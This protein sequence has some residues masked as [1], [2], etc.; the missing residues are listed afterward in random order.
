MFCIVHAADDREPRGFT[1]WQKPGILKGSKNMACKSVIVKGIIPV[2][3]IMFLASV[4]HA[5]VNLISDGSFETPA[6]APGQYVVPNS[7]FGAW[8]YTQGSPVGNGYDWSAVLN[9]NQQSNGFSGSMVYTGNDGVQFAGIQGDATVS[10][11]FTAT[12]TSALLSWLDAGR[13]SNFGNGCCTGNQSYNVL[14]NGVTIA[15]EAT[16]TARDFASHSVALDGLIAGNTYTL[17]FAGQKTT[18]ETA[19]LD[20]VSVTAAV[21][22][23]AA[24]AL[25]IAGFGM[26]GITMRRRTTRGSIAPLNLA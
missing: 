6:L 17:A 9:N 8:T 20:N 21:P 7:T 19:F 16:T 23:P 25:M 10:Q 12:S 15:S 13:P 5:S 14:L 22:E 11:S 3:A 24:W 4:A 2:A 26:V 1:A 18:D